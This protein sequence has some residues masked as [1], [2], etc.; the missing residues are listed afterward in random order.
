M[1]DNAATQDESKT[2]IESNLHSQTETPRIVNI[3]SET[4]RPDILKTEDE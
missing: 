2:V 3:D 1:F 4:V